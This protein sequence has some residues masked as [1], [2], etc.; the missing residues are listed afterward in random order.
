MVKGKCQKNHVNFSPSYLHLI[1]LHNHVVV[2]GK[3]KMNHKPK[4]VHKSGITD[5]DIALVLKF[6]Q[7]ATSERNWTALCSHWKINSHRHQ[8]TRVLQMFTQWAPIH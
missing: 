4:V 7:V 8:L 3:W 1:V 5:A 2:L 6:W